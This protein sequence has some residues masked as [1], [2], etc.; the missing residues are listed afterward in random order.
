MNIQKKKIYTFCKCAE[1]KNI[2]TGTVYLRK[3]KYIMYVIVAN[4]MVYSSLGFIPF[5]LCCL[6]VS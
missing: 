4:T 6:I 1:K 2:Y 5:L 3:K